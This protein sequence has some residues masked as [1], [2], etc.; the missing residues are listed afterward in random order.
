MTARAQDVLALNFFYGLGLCFRGGTIADEKMEGIKA[1]VAGCA[2]CSA[3]NKR[4]NDFCEKGQLL[5]LSGPKT[6]RRFERR[7]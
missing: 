5:F 3:A 2:T 1:H 7:K 4:V 6:M